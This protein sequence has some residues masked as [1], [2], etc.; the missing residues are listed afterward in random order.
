VNGTG[1]WRW[2]LS[3][4][5]ELT[6]E[7]GRRLWRRV[8]RWLAEPVQGEPLRV[9]PERWLFA[10]GERVRLFATLQDAEFRPVAGAAI[11]AELLAEG[12]RP[13]RVRFEPRA[14]GSYV[15]ELDGLPAARYRV[16][17]RAT[18]G[19]ELGRASAEFAIDR[20]S[21]EMTQTLPDSATLAALAAA[22][23]GRFAAGD[24]LARWARGLETRALARGHGQT[25]RLWE[26]PWLFALVIGALGVEW[27]WRRRRGLP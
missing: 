15:A 3:S 4:T 9:R 1:V 13:R 27:A 8:V 25:V 24:D 14:A 6:A 10:G 26:S 5:D 12:A 11:E 7:R 18:R 17:A 16:N 19:G 20:W 21:L 2:S 22:T 23:G